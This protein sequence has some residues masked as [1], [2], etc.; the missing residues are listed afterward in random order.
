[1]NQGS[2]CSGVGGLDIGVVQFAAH[3]VLELIEELNERKG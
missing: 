1:M 3:V 2:F